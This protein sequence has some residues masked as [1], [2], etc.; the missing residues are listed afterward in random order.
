MVWHGD[1]LLRATARPAMAVLGGLTLSITVG[2]KGNKG[3][4]WNKN[5]SLSERSEVVVVR[6]SLIYS[7]LFFNKLIVLLLKG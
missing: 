1:G 4:K 3:N 7:S 5:L 2:N 6:A